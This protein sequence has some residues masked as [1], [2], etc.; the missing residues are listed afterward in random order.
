MLDQT[1][2]NLAIMAG[3]LAAACSVE[4]AVGTLKIPHSLLLCTPPHGDSRWEACRCCSAL[5]QV[6]GTCKTVTYSCWRHPAALLCR[7]A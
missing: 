4:P 6:G 5:A 3:R 1:P 7:N 2:Q